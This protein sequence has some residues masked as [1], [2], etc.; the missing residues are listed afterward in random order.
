MADNNELALPP[1]HEA[2]LV[3][4][5]EDALRQAVVKM[6]RKTGFDVFE[7][8]DGSSAIDLLRTEGG[9]IDVILLDMTLPGAPS[10]Q[11]VTEAAK[12]R[13]DMRVILTSAYSDEMVAAKI[14]ALQVRGFI[15]KPFRFPDLVQKLRSP[16]VS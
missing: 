10:H 16:P 3:V 7:A 1:Q 4:E 14:T 13:P 5:D 11:V 2:V 9:K 6:L 12:A 15:R 8:A